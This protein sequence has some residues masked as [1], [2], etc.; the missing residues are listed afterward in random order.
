MSTHILIIEDD[1]TFSTMLSVWL[2]KKNFEVTTASSVAAAVK[3][4][5]QN[6]HTPQ[7]VL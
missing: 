3:V 2:R 5:L 4:L 1:L 7:L 6:E